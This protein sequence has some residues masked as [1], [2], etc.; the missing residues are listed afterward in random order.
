MR[1]QLA[2][3]PTPCD[4]RRRSK[5]TAD[6][7]DH[8]QAAPNKHGL[9]TSMPGTEAEAIE[10]AAAE[11]KQYAA[12]ADGGAAHL[13]THSGSAYWGR[14]RRSACATVGF[15]ETC[16]VLRAD[17]PGLAHLYAR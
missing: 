1:A 9:A 7:L 13:I 16:T 2:R 3:R 6:H 12:K 14:S 15:Y 10:K 8:L 4:F 5:R 17:E 11:F